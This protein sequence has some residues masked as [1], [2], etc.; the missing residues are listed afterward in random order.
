MTAA[1]RGALISA[2]VLAAAASLWSATQPA[3]A[4]GC[5]IAIK[6]E[7]N[8]ESALVVDK[9]GLEQ[10]ILSLDLKS[11]GDE[12]A[13]VVLPVPGVPK[14]AAIAKGDPLAYLDQATQPPPSVGSS[15]G[16]DGAT[17]GAAPPVEVLGREDV[18]GYDVTRLASNDRKALDTWLDRNG[19]K[20]PDGAEPIFASYIRQG[21]K[22]VA[23]RLAPNS[24]GRLKPLRVSFQTDIPVY[25]MKL[26]QLSSRPIDLTLYTLADG[27]RQVQG[28]DTVYNAP[29]T[30]L[31]PP[32]P[33][34]LADLFGEGDYVTRMQ[35]TN[36]P[37]D[38]FDTDLV[39]EPLTEAD[40]AAVAD[41]TQPTPASG[42]DKA[43][44]SDSSGGG[45]TGL[46]LTLALLAGFIGVWILVNRVE[47]RRSATSAGEKADDP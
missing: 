44:T 32:P 33:P 24:S 5:G 1:V 29:V 19:Y 16:G 22:F 35:V 18:G 9:P 10:I 46:W 14:V 37:P 21:W 27:Q 40:A 8:Q 15:G 23:I 26:S 39:I 6:A 41:D 4:C 34:E 17:A 42:N 28:L 3:S 11:Q 2:I 20:V 36:A 43:T 13:A 47:R 38:S 31:D 7:V 45:T 30:A 12:R 25:P